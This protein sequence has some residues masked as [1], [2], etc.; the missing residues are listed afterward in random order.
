MQSHLKCVFV[1]LHIKNY[2][3]SIVFNLDG[4]IRTGNYQLA[5]FSF[6]VNYDPAALDDDGCDQFSPRGANDSRICD[7]VVDRDEKRALA[8]SDRSRRKALYAAIQRRRMA[9]MGGVPLYFL[10][11]VGVVN[12]DLKGYTPSR[13]IVP[14]WNAWQWSL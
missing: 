11:R 1:D 2:P 9:D 8:L 4:P 3:Y 5:Q 6:S 14:E 7:R 12:D 10:E 13:G